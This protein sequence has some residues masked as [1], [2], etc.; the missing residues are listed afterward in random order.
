MGAKRRCSEAN[1]ERRGD[2]PKQTKI[3]WPLSS[4]PS[5]SPDGNDSDTEP[6]AKKRMA[7]TSAAKKDPTPSKLYKDTIKKVDKVFNGL[8][9][10]YNKNLTRWSGVVS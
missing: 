5:R 2:A 8:V 7:R 3:S 1:L 10:M 4:Q 9:K 6:P